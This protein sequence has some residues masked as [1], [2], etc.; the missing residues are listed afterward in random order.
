MISARF[1]AGAI[2]T[3][4]HMNGTSPETRPLDA[5]SDPE[6][7]IARTTLESPAAEEVEQLEALLGARAKELTEQ[8]AELARLRALLRDAA[9]RLDSSTGAAAE[10]VIAELRRER[11]QAV[12]RALESEAAR[13]EIGFRLDEVM[14][15]LA[16]AGVGGTVRGLVSTLAETQE[17]RET[18]QARLLLAEQDLLELRAE[19]RTLERERAE[20][21]E[22]LELEQLKARR[23]SEHWRG[24]LDAPAAACL[25]GERDGLRARSEESERA[26]AAAAAR[27][28]EL[29]QVV[30]REIA[31]RGEV[32]SAL[33]QAQA[34][35]MVLLE[36]LERARAIKPNPQT[37][38][39]AEALRAVRAELNELAAA[40]RGAHQRKAGRGGLGG[41]AVGDDPEG[42]TTSIEPVGSLELQLAAS[43]A[44]LRHLEARLASAAATVGGLEASAA[45]PGAAQ[46]LAALR[47]LLERR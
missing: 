28:A 31:G 18:A 7:M 20:L 5:I 13:A 36:E 6:P 39:H 11:D 14:G 4:G 34:E 37:E 8:R 33:A 17:S 2:S 44:R 25:R 47:V 46:Q 12:A 43:E 27:I 15:H 32:G 9:T 16:A 38:R 3:A 30:A 35:R 10:P 1:D 26:F 29:E 22:Q 40:L 23:M 21:R 19:A 41:P 24:G 45:S 42:A